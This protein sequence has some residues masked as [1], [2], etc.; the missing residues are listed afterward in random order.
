MITKDRMKHF[1]FAVFLF[2]W[3]S[4]PYVVLNISGYSL[5]ALH[6]FVVL[7]PIF[8]RRINSVVFI[9]CMGII[10][11]FLFA[12]LVGV[13]Y[14]TTTAK[15]ITHGLQTIFC[16]LTILYFSKYNIL[17]A[18]PQK[19]LNATVLVVLAYLLYQFIGRFLGWDYTFLKINNLQLHSAGKSEGFQR[20]YHL[21]GS[22]ILELRPNS[23][24]IEPGTLGYFGVGMFLLNK[25]ILFKL[26]SAFILL[27]SMSLGAYFI[28]C[29]VI[30]CMFL[31]EKRFLV[32]SIIMF[33]ST[34]L[35]FILHNYSEIFR[36]NVTERI[37]RVFFEG[38]FNGEKR[39][40]HINVFYDSYL[41]SPIY[42]YGLYGEKFILGDTALSMVYQ[43][44]L[45]ERG[46]IG[47][48]FYMLP[49]LVF[50]FYRSSKL[51]KTIA[52]FYFTSMLWKP[53][54]FFIPSFLFA[55][56]MLSKR[57]RIKKSLP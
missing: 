22:R 13:F 31:I 50:G 19:L 54:K 2:G 11:S 7:T 46:L 20:G 42:G 10:T 35:V 6:I 1:T 48:L 24:F 29:F 38:G 49:M 28:F 51:Q 36:T 41:E 27:L 8:I 47:T 52:I 26:I 18:T 53:Y 39:L 3:L 44:L 25:K 57:T 15:F 37:L 34:N 55:S 43:M 45:V 9:A 56:L 17:S 40:R 23:F 4:Y 14:F 16:V 5:T 21:L 33:I 30:I 32:L 12:S